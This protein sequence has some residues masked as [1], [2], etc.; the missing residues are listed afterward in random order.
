[1]RPIAGVDVSTQGKRLGYLR[2]RLGMIAGR[3]V[4]KKDV[5]AALGVSG[6]TIG[7]W[8]SDEARPDVDRLDVI[9]A[10]YGATKEW[11]LWGNGEPPAGVRLLVP[12]R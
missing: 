7:G 9:A 10:Y 3:D 1:M 8:E 12:P 5:G 2:R 11:I 6:Q 4:G